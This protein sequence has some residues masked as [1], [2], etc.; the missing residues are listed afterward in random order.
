[1][2]TYLAGDTAGA[3][4]YPFPIITQT[5]LYSVPAP[6]QLFTVVIFFLKLVFLTK[7]TLPIW[8]TSMLDIAQKYMDIRTRTAPLLLYIMLEAVQ[9]VQNIILLKLNSLHATTFI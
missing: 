7:I 5:I 3:V 9:A 6:E 2:Y 8:K 4:D 1:M